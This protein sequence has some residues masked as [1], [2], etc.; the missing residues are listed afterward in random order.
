MCSAW[1]SSGVGW[2]V[3]AALLADETVLGSVFP[4]KHPPRSVEEMIEVRAPGR[5][6]IVMP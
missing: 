2:I 4:G 3:F 1:S 5:A 6:S